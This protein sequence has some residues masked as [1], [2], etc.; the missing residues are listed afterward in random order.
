MG[1]RPSLAIILIDARYGGVVEQIQRHSLILGLLNIQK[2][3]LAVN[4][5]DKR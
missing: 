5:K 3:I 2:I 4:K 1:I